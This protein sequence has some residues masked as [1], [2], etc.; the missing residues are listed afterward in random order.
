MSNDDPF[1]ALDSDRTFIMPS[2]GQ[3]G[4]RETP[5]NVSPNAVVRMSSNPTADVPM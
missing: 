4:P 3:R 5:G 2:P 1:A